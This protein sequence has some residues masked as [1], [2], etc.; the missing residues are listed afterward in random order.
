VMPSHFGPIFLTE[1][2]VLLECDKSTWDFFAGSQGEHSY[3]CYWDGPPYQPGS[4]LLMR[5][6]ANEA[7]H[8]VHPSNPAGFRV[9][10]DGER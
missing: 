4:R 6:P 7:H 8:F 10:E 2:Y 1:N 9:A 3:L 5:V